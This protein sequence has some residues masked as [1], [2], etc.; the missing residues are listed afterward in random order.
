[1]MSIEAIEYENKKAE[2]RARANETNLWVAQTNGDENVRL[3]PYIGDYTP[4]GWELVETYFVDNSGMGGQNEPALT[5]KQFLQEVKQ[6]HGYGIISV[7]QFQ[8]YIGEFRKV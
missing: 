7:G 8:I 4:I 2:D 6:N 5:L 1:M 3:A